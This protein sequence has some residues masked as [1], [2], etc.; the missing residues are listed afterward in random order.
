MFSN[1]AGLGQELQRIHNSF[2]HNALVSPPGRNHNVLIVT[3]SSLNCRL[4]KAAQFREAMCATE[5]VTHKPEPEEYRF[6]PTEKPD[7][8]QPEF[9]VESNNTPLIVGEKMGSY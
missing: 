3:T 8:L 9:V 4:L 1:F 5:E 7:I 2:N 6:E